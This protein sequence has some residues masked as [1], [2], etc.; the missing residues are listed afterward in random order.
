MGSAEEAQIQA[1]YKMGMLRDVLLDRCPGAHVIRDVLPDRCPGA[2]DAVRVQKAEGAGGIGFLGEGIGFL[3]E[4]MDMVESSTLFVGSAVGNAYALLL[5]LLLD[6][7]GDG[8]SGRRGIPFEL[9][10][11]D[12][13]TSTIVNQSAKHLI[14]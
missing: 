13:C 2:H 6:D 9:M 11:F 5:L 12:P 3:E 14:K 7:D 4:G 1:Y 10:R 8:E